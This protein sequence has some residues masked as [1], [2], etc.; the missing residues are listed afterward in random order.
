MHFTEI[1]SDIF[2]IEKDKIFDDLELQNIESWDSMAHMELISTIEDTYEL[3][4]TGDEIVD[5]KKIGDIKEI[6]LRN[7]KNL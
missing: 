4:F 7:K 2:N 1:I 5:I 6:I 3:T